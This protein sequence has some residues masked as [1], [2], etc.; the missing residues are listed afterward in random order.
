M[1]LSILFVFPFEVPYGEDM[2]GEKLFSE[3]KPDLCIFSDTELKI[4]ASVK[5]HFKGWRA[6]EI[7]EFSHSER[8]YTETPNARL[9]SYKYAE[10]LQM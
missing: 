4:L 5:E 2:I 7:S 6:K 9:I 1:P 3:I 8:G 10:G